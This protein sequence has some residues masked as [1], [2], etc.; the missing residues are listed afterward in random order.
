MLCWGSMIRGRILRMWILIGSLN[1][2]SGERRRRRTD[3]ERGLFY[4]S[5]YS[6]T[7]GFLRTPTHT[8]GAHALPAS[9]FSYFYVQ[10]LSPLQ[11]YHTQCISS[12]CCPNLAHLLSVLT[13]LHDT[14]QKYI[15]SPASQSLHNGTM[16]IMSPAQFM[17]HFVYLCT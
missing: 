6:F 10:T 14:V 3:V 5:L 8:E 17:K 1:A 2:R 7:V 13:V 9:P 15:R 4:Y 12:V 11:S 16:T